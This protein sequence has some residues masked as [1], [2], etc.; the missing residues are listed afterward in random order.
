MAVFCKKC[1]AQLKESS[2]F[3]PG[4]GT[5]AVAAQVQ[6]LAPTGQPYQA[7]QSQYESQYGS[8]PGQ[9]GYV[10]PQP[11]PHLPT[12]TDAYAKQ[13]LKRKTLPILLPVVIIAAVLITAVIIAVFARGDGVLTV[14]EDPFTDDEPLII[15]V[16]GVGEEPDDDEEPAEDPD[17]E[18]ETIERGTFTDFPVIIGEGTKFPLNAMISIPDNVTG[19]VPA[20]VLV[21]GD[22]VFDMDEEV[23]GNRPF[24][25]IAEYIASYGIAV[26]RYDKRNFKHAYKM[27]EMFGGSMTAREE[28][29]EDMLLATELI[30]ADPRVDEDRVFIL[31]HSFGGFIAPRAHF[32]GG[33]FAGIISLAGTPLSYIDRQYYWVM[34][35]IAKMP[36][37]EE[38]D[39]EYAKWENWYEEIKNYLINTPDE[40]LKEEEMSGYSLYYHKDLESHPIAEYVAR[41]TI[42]FLI[43]QGTDDFAVDVE[44]DYAAWQDLFLGRDNATFKLYEGLNHFFFPSSGYGYEDW[45]KEYSVPGHTDEQVLADIVEWIYAN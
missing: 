24:R 23:F 20:L 39:A 6:P 33:D 18:P 45:E 4:C 30:K 29:T 32:E 25:D 8:P 43:L 22:G 35:N 10:S 9:Q 11:L 34:E 37:G 1:G 16:P 27:Q 3:C 7:P 5:M 26:I 19:K 17:D 31:G 13:A 40:D 21:H 12:D 41:A 2:K 44:H 28:V 38:K 36:E 14:I 42:P 15:E